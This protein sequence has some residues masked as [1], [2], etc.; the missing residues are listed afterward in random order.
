M[1][2]RHGWH[3]NKICPIKESG[4]VLR[5]WL[6]QEP[7]PS[8]REWRKCSEQRE[9]SNLFAKFARLAQFALKPRL[10]IVNSP[11]LLEKTIML[12]QGEE[13]GQG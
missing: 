13:K 5:P 4:E 2:S 3:Y 6:S 8:E 10:N 7:I 11:S 9:F 1:W 12:R